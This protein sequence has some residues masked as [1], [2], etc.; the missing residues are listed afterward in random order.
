MNWHYNI[1]RSL[2][3]V[4]PPKS[5]PRIQIA[6]GQI[7]S[8]FSASFVF[9]PEEGK[10]GQSCQG[11]L[12]IKSNAHPGSAPIVFSGLQVKFDDIIHTIILQHQ[13]DSQ[14]RQANGNVVLFSVAL[15]APA[16]KTRRTRAALGGRD[17]VERQI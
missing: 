10:A 11:Q 9:K 7:L 5:K 16:E 13:A 17:C 14:T 15:S 12:S 2:E 8:F 4:A 3:G 6:D 1:T